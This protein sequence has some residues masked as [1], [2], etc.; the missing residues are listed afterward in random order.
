MSALPHSSLGLLLL[1][2]L[3]LGASCAAPDA[4]PPHDWRA[5]PHHL[6][7]LGAG[8]F[9]SEE[10][11]STLGVDYEV[12]VSQLLGLGGVVEQAFGEIDATTVLA[13]ADVHLTDHWIVQLGPGVELR[14]PEDEAVFRLGVMYEFV[15][16]GW[17]LS[18]QLHYDVTSGENALVGALALGFGF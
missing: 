14:E 12:R 4:H 8:T 2:L 9:E 3:L 15:R 18:P 16:E 17:T 13:V 7:L 11:A 10:S 6:S 5:E 1:G